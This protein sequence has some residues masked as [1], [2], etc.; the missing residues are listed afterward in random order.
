M[1]A[2]P[3]VDAIYT[4][5]RTGVLSP[6]QR[7]DQRAIS[8]HLDVSRTPLREALRALEADGI[9]TRTPNAGY[10]VAKLSAADL[11]QYY[12]IR[13]FLE[14]EILR[15]IEWPS[16]EQL[17]YLKKLNE[18]CR[19]A[20]KQGA[21]EQLIAANREFHF[22]MFRWSPLTIMLNETDRIWRVSDPY[23]AL[24]L[25]NQERRK[26]VPG[27]H[28]AMIAAIEQQDVAKLIALSDKHRSA[29]RQLL[30]E[31]LGSNLPGS[32]LMLP[33]SAQALNKSLSRPAS[34]SAQGR[35]CMHDPRLR[36]LFSDRGVG[37]RATH[38]ISARCPAGHRCA[39]RRTRVSQRL[40]RVEQPPAVDQD[41]LVV[42]AAPRRQS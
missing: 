19:T 41:I 34:S 40:P 29:S 11:L 10:A 18:D 23:R 27:D 17:E 22:T 20:V 32:L 15:T 13:T 2:D 26:R 8:E 16:S 5:I 33:Q 36:G 1:A 3:L 9:L 7:V 42:V 24:H 38:P 35:L 14:T 39:S 37:T 12:S 31:L 21:V 6:G 28:D 4:L 25:S 30:T